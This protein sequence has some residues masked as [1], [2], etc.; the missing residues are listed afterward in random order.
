[1]ADQEVV[2]I[3]RNKALFAVSLSLLVF[4]VLSSAGSG[5]QSSDKPQ[6]VTCSFSNPGY[7][8]WCRQNAPVPKDGTPDQVC[9]GILNCLNDTQCNATYC[10]ATQLRGGWKL[11]QVEAK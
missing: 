5:T 9:Q 2:V 6:T 10:D 11:E 3:K 1:V 8:G 7:S 4:V